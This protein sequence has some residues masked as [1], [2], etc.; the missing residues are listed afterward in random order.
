MDF[1]V[2]RCHLC[3]SQCSF[4]LWVSFWD[5]QPSGI[6][7]RAAKFGIPHADERLSQSEGP[8]VRNK[9]TLRGMVG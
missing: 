7:G 2:L 8:S 4:Y 1:T 6:D 5:D 3:D 9:E